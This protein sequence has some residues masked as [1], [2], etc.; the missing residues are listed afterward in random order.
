MDLSVE[1]VES[2][3]AR[4][5]RGLARKLEARR[6]DLGLEHGLDR[7]LKMCSP[8]STLSVP[9]RAHPQGRRCRGLA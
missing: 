5:R 2:L 9:E 8:R 3:L 6:A 1:A 7:L 4:A